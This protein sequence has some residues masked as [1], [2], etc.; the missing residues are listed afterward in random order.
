MASVQEERGPDSP[1]E[2]PSEN[3]EIVENEES[4][5]DE[6][7]EK[8][9]EESMDQGEEDDLNEAEEKDEEAEEAEKAE[10]DEEQLTSPKPLIIRKPV[11]KTPT[12]P[13]ALING[14]PEPM[15]VDD[16]LPEGWWRQVTQRK[17]G[18]SAGKYDVYIHS[19]YKKKF[20]SQQEIARYA[21]K[22]DL[23]L[24]IKDFDFSV[25]GN[26][27]QSPKKSSKKKSKKA[28]KSSSPNKP[29]KSKTPKGE[30]SASKK[31]KRE[32]LTISQR[33]VVK[34]AFPGLG[35]KRKPEDFDFLDKEEEKPAKKRAEEE[36]EEVEENE[37]V[38]NAD[39]S[40]NEENEDSDSEREEEQN[41]EEEEEVNNNSHESL[42]SD[43]EIEN[44][45]PGEE[46]SSSHVASPAAKERKNSA[47]AGRKDSVSSTRKSSMSSGSPLARL[48]KSDYESDASETSSP[49]AKHRKTDSKGSAASLRRSYSSIST[50]YEVDE[51]WPPSSD[52]EDVETKSSNGDDINSKSSDEDNSKLPIKKRYTKLTECSYTA[53]PHNKDFPRLRLSRDI[54]F[55]PPRSP[56]NLVQESL[57][58]DPWKLLVAT[59][60]LNRT[61]GKAALP[62]L[63]TFLETWPEAE[64]CCDAD[65][66]Q[67]A[68]MLQP[69]GLHEKRAKILIRMSY[70]YLHKDWKYP[71][72]LYGIGKYGNDSYR[73]FCVNEWKQVSPTDHKLNDYHR[74]LWANHRSLGIS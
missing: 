6:S 30:R 29:K 50:D 10:K 55:V 49:K 19:P 2:T 71:I 20:R 23:E 70:E 37:E 34:M 13:K 11:P 64:A 38:N 15:L 24:N 40:Q 7:Y 14:M 65:V 53:N 42:M 72:E 31:K 32:M 12:I 57:F 74:W 46:A 16:R 61:A 44:T 21:E 39:V 63:W 25:Y 3:E 48:N 35:K 47:S 43:N 60:F 56:F 66:N 41:E 62:I 5:A 26:H 36:E 1:E 45:E 54:N 22:N 58:H 59:I 52:E 69:L 8:E 9:E 51:E 17:E 73:I 33:L 27:N 68:Q 4:N 18:A 28:A 67:I